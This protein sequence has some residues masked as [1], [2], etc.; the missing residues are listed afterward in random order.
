MESMLTFMLTVEASEV[1]LVLSHQFNKKGT[2][3]MIEIVN[4]IMNIP[5]YRNL[6][7]VDWIGLFTRLK[8]CW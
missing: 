3:V 5:C 7:S 4:V 8:A 1:S 6:V 2:V